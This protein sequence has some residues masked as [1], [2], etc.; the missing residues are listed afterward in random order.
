MKPYSC[1]LVLIDDVTG[2]TNAMKEDSVVLEFVC[3][4]TKF[5][6]TDIAKQTIKNKLDWYLVLIKTDLKCG[7]AIN[8]IILI[9]F[10]VFMDFETQHL[11]FPCRGNAVG[12]SI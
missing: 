4:C 1:P 3:K 9:C 11:L 10:S 12:I 6:W 7:Y 5:T 2:N 8:S